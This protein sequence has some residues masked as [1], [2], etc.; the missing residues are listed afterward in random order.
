MMNSQLNIPAT[1]Y[2][3]EVLLASIKQVNRRLG[4]F[5]NKST[6]GWKDENNGPPGNQT[7]NLYGH[8]Q[9][10]HKVIITLQLSIRP[11]SGVISALVS[12]LHDHGCYTCTKISWFHQNVVQV[13]IFEICL[14]L[15]MDSKAVKFFL[16]KNVLPPNSKERSHA[17][18]ANNDWSGYEYPPLL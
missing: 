8:N 17:S 18:K 11:I 13:P 5:R 16:N 1:W 6:H 14:I 7:T 2:W 4:G 15:Q 12:K 3:G 10:L 9:S